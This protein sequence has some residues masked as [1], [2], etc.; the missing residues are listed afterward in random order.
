MYIILGESSPNVDIIHK[1]LHTIGQDEYRNIHEI[2]KTITQY[3]CITKT[4]S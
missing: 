3:S 1:T 2:R 4:E